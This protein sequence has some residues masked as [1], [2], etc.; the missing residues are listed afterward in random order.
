[1]IDMEKSIRVGNKTPSMT[2][3]TSVSVGKP[4]VTEDTSPHTTSG[5]KTVTG[6]KLVHGMALIS[7][8]GPKAKN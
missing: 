6:G 4:S 3:K 7:A 5:S 1:V 2:V 8:A